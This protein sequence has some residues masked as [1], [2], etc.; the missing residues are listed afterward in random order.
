MHNRES[1]SKFFD[2]NFVGGPS[3]KMKP[4]VS[5]DP[6]NSRAPLHSEAAGN[7]G[8]RGSSPATGAL[9]G[10]PAS[11]KPQTKDDSALKASLGSSKDHQ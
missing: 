3:S 5:T 8:I 9:A 1:K 10:G 6:F 11:S 2:E 7:K 4:K